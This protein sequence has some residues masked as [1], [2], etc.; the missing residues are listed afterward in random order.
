MTA[1][2]RQGGMPS[3][4][5]ALQALD[6]HTLALSV[7]DASF[8]G[9]DGEDL[10]R[11]SPFSR[12]GARFLAFVR[13]LGFDALQMGPPG[14][15]PDDD[16]SPYRGSI[17]ARSPLSVALAPL[18][19]EPEWGGI[20]DADALREAVARRP[21]GAC[22]RVAYAF[23]RREHD[24]LL[25]RALDVLRQPEGGAPSAAAREAR[26]ARLAERDAF[27]RE[28]AD[29]LERYGL[30]EALRRETGHTDWR[31][32]SGPDGA[33]PGE[34]RDLDARLWA[35]RSGEEHAC[36][37]RR[38][39]VAARAADAIALFR[40]GQFLVHAQHDRFRETARRLDVR[41]VGDLQV[42]WAPEDEWCHPGLVL[43]GYR[44]GAPPSRTNPEGQPWGYPVLDPEG[45]DARAGSPDAPGPVRR[46]LADRLDRML[47]DYDGVRIDHPHGFVCP[48]V[49][50]ATDA[51]A[52]RAVR[53]GARLF[54]S[55]D[56]PDHP[57]LARFAIA[58]PDQIHP[59]PR[60][61][62][63]A[64]DWVVAL[65]PA[66]VAR[67]ARLVDEIV[68][69]VRRRGGGPGNV[70]CEVLSTLPLPVQRVLER[71]GLG[72]F[73]VTQKASLTDP[74]DGYRPENARP[75]DWIMLGN[76][77]T[78]PIWRVVCEWAAQ[79]EVEARANDLASRLAPR[80]GSRAAFAA[81][82]VADPGR[83]ANACLAD[84][85]ASR[86]RHV[87]VFFA[88]LFGMTECYNDPGTRSGGNWVLRV[89][90]DYAERHARGAAALRALDL[91]LALAIALRSGD[92]GADRLRLAARL[93]SERAR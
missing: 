60:P 14:Q 24:A 68:A 11:G 81:W 34:G 4:A 65:E 7:H 79:G 85:F 49:Y 83:I 5:A 23:A 16:P 38:R 10:G 80:A 87:L 55:P 36:V 76:H 40:F 82:L 35:P 1:G 56:L 54:S 92:A 30:F 6:V 61:D 90:P 75:E 15:T 91:R 77:D 51:D 8:P 88:D 31:R 25:G 69:A 48:W 63:W 78:P 47:R 20:L 57:R 41:L 72:R 22:E 44:M 52:Y 93:E 71:H 66:Q 39:A 67:Y 62:R 45:F 50:D 53:A 3:I 13:G 46:F 89:P 43:E 84:A 29:W 2:S 19:D 32:W 74:T 58:R 26:R 12:G 33:E 18:V 59:P 70:A 27:E 73:R 21:A 28:N 37:A 64:D 86:A 9:D 42:G 17:V